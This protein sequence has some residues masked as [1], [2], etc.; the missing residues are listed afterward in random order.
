MDEGLRG[1]TFLLPIQ[2]DLVA[3]LLAAIAAT[4]AACR[5]SY[6]VVG[7]CMLAL[8]GSV[9]GGLL[10]DSVFL[11]QIPVVMQHSEYL[12][13]ILTGVAGALFTF[14]YAE[15]FVICSPTPT[16]FA[17]RHSIYS[18]NRALIADTR[19]KP[20]S[21]SR[22]T[23]WRRADPRRAG[24]RR[25]VMFRPGHL[26]GLAALAGCVLFV[27]LSHGYGLETQRAAWIAIF[28]TIAMRLAAIR[29]NWTTH[30]VKSLLGRK[31][32]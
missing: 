13:T 16:R 27:V 29:F 4:W 24:R 31:E 14:R 30:A 15:R 25:A 11:R 32:G 2:F 5:R 26:Y 6:D 7:V 17:W 19:R 12:W 23:R 20:R 21:S 18:A 1:V 8:V 22:V 3:T 28:L 10:R 9:G